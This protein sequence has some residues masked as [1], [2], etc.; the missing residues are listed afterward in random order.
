MISFDSGTPV[1]L[2][3]YQMSIEQPVCR[4]HNISTHLRP[5]RKLQNQK[6]VLL[7]LVNFI[8]FIGVRSPSNF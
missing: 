5:V 4:Q 7:T 2:I 8:Y 1:T 3:I 6:K